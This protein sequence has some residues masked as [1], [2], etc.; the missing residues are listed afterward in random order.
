MSA[1]KAEELG[2]IALHLC[3]VLK[4]PGIQQLE[5][6][7]FKGKK[8]GR[9]SACEK[10]QT[11]KDSLGW[12]VVQPVTECLPSMCVVLGSFSTTKKKE[13]KRNPI[14]Q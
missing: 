8:V 6:D 14:W 4:Q 12:R 1:N 9:D 5:R 2:A 7:F 10:M 11:E 3:K 13:K